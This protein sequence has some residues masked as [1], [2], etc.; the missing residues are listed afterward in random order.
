MVY[1]RALFCSLACFKATSA[2]AEPTPEDARSRL[3]RILQGPEFQPRGKEPGYFD[4]LAQSAMDW[5]SEVSNDLLEAIDNLL[6]ERDSNF[7]VFAKWLAS[8][9]EPIASFFGSLLDTLGWLGWPIFALALLYLGRKLIRYLS[10]IYFRPRHS[11]AS[12]GEGERS[13]KRSRKDPFS[14]GSSEEALFALRENLREDLL[15]AYEL[16]QSLTDRELL[17]QTKN[18]GGHYEVFAK[19]SRVFERLEYAGLGFSATDFDELI[20]EY[21]VLPPLSKQERRA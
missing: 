16:T 14:L 19:V 13:K 8:V 6:P 17:A 4:T 9:L 15:E 7:S 2:L 10:G 11:L 5:L 12:A 21:R 1:L 18:S 3:E 20:A